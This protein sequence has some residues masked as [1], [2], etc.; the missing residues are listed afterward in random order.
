MQYLL[1]TSNVESSSAAGAYL[2]VKIESSLLW[3]NLV[4]LL[5]AECI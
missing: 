2:H 3:Y 1:D 5:A 4:C